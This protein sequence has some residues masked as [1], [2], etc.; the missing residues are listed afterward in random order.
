[1]EAAG[2]P[3]IAANQGMASP[4][5]IDRF[6]ET[7]AASLDMLQQFIGKPITVQVEPSYNQEQYDIIL[8]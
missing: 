5:V 1:M 8:M 3:S 4:A 6:L 7:E 2:F